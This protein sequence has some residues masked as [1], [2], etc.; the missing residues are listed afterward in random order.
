MKLPEAISDLIPQHHGT[1]LVEYFYNKAAKAS[2]EAV[3]SVG[4]FRYPGPKPR[5][6]EG[7]ILMIADAVEA[8]SRSLEEPSREK[9]EKMIRLIVMKRINDGQFDECDL[10]TRQLAR[11]IETLAGALE[12]SMHSRVAYPWQEKLK[13]VAAIAALK[14]R[15]KA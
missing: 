11:I 6:I 3:V 1:H 12:A 13:K 5:S 10:S 15:V 2:H 9:I 14:H 7:A 8:A 4:D